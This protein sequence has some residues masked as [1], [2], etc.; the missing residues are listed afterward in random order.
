MD[1]GQKTLSRRLSKL[2]GNAALCVQKKADGKIIS[3]K[4]KVMNRE[5]MRHKNMLHMV[6]TGSGESKA[7]NL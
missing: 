7:A 2:Q 4:G 5:V 6:N 3:A 1:S